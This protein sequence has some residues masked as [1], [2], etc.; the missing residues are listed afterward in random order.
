[1]L[2]RLLAAALLLC[3]L[4]ASCVAAEIDTLVEEGT[5]RFGADA[6]MDE[7]PESA[8]KLGDELGLEGLSLGE[9]VRMSPAEI[10][11]AVKISAISAMENVRGSLFAIIGTVLLCAALGCIGSGEGETAVVFE[12]VAVLAVTAALSAPVLRCV[13]DAAD[14]IVDASMFL[15]SYVPVYSTVIT[16]G[17]QPMSA[18]GYSLSV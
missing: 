12:T 1:M 18:A 7:V 11:H 16:A 15:L 9:I 14:S 8:R 4:S 10:Y 3:F 5:A 6:L 17:G 2:K 13:E